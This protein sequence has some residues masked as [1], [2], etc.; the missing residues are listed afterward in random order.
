VEVKGTKDTKEFYDNRGWNTD[1]RGVS[2]DQDLFGN[3]ENGPLRQRMTERMWA[4]IS[5]HMATDGGLSALEVGCGGTP[6]LDLLEDCTEYCGVDF[7][8]AGLELAAKSLE[9]HPKKTRF[10]EADAVDLPFEDGV[11]DTVYSA[12][13]IYHIV[14]RNSQRAALKEMIRVLKP[15]GALVLVTANPRPIL[16]PVRFLIRLVA[17]TPFLSGIA[18]K[19]KGSSLIPYNPAKI[20]AYKQIFA[21]CTTTKVVNGGIAS[22]KFNQSV[23]ELK[24]PSKAVWLFFGFLD[25]N[26]PTMSAYLGN[27]AVF[28]VRK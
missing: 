3:K 18:R 2:V 23:S 12:H 19:L 10:V 8:S 24:W 9:G 16:F 26:F 6:C 13:M 1:D 5:Q 21:G 20:S 27:Y 22:T 14:D 4:R 25:R 28:L 15:G 11:F 7:S 17:D